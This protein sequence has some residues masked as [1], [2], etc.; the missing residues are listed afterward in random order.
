[1]TDA[2]ATS[3]PPTA[4]EQPGGAADR[5][6]AMPD[7]L[8]YLRVIGLAALIGTPAALGAALFLALVHQ[9]EHR[10]WTDLPD[11]LGA[12]SPPWYLV[13]GLP[14][15]GAVIVLA[16]RLWLPGDGGHAPLLGVAGGATPL[17]AAPGVLVAAIGSLA[18]GAV[19]GPEAPL[20]ALGSVFG[21]VVG[22]FIRLGP[23]EEK[24]VGAAGSFAAISA[25]FGGPVVGGVFMLEGSG[26]EPR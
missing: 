1:V 23:Q 26:W 10:L 12:S 6:A 15:V 20:I 16:A 9:V 24:V 2:D 5:G 3:D 11:A 25:L 14:V 7:R 22:T 4:R 21:L 13:V 8:A 17:H 18:F 19:L